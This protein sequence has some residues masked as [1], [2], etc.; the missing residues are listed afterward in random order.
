MAHLFTNIG[1]KEIPSSDSPLY[2]VFTDGCP[3]FSGHHLT[4][5]FSKFVIPS[6]VP[7]AGNAA[8]RNTKSLDALK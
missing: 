5:W 4:P 3:L 2:A 1:P 6:K 7:P 8:C